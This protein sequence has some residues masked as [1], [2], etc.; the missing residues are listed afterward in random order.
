M[1]INLTMRPIFLDGYDVFGK[2]DEWAKAG[3]DDE[4]RDWEV[5]RYGRL[6]VQVR[7]SWRFGDSQLGSI[8]KVYPTPEEAAYQA[9]EWFS[10]TYPDGPPPVKYDEPD[11]DD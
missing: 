6:D 2:L 8:V 3:R 9:L 10:K 1:P 5:R 7:L 11:E 4:G